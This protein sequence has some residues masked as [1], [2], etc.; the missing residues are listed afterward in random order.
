MNAWP[1]QHSV[2]I[3]QQPPPLFIKVYYLH[4]KGKHI[5]EKVLKVNCLNL[6]LMN[7]AF[8]ACDF[9]LFMFSCGVLSLC[10]ILAESTT[11]NFISFTLTITFITSLRHR[12]SSTY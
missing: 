11:F 4:E 3:M 7:V 1:N 8:F 5:R 12:S 6:N 2:E 10:E 9:L